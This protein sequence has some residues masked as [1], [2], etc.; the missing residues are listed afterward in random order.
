MLFMLKNQK[1][2]FFVLKTKKTTTKEKQQKLS[3]HFDLI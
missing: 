1:H 3:K 2:T